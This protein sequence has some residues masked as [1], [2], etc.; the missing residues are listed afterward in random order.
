MSKTDYNIILKYLMDESSKGLSYEVVKLKYIKD[1]DVEAREVPIVNSQFEKACEAFPD[2]EIIQKVLSLQFI[3]DAEC[4]KY[5]LLDPEAKKVEEITVHALR[6]MFTAE[7]F[8]H[9]QRYRLNTT[10]MG[11]NPNSNALFYTDETSFLKK[12]NL[13]RP[14][15]W[16]VEYFF[17]DLKPPVTPLPDVYKEYL[18]HLTNKSELSYTYLLNFMASCVQANKKAFT[19][20]TL[21]GGQGIGKGVLFHILKGLLGPENVAEIRANRL[22]EVK[23]NAFAKN[24]K[25]LFFDELCIRNELDEQQ[26][27]FYVNPTLEIEEKGKDSKQYINYANILIASNSMN[28][29]RVENDDRRYS[30]ADMGPNKLDILSNSKYKM[31]I[32]TYVETVLLNKSNLE[33]LGRFLLNFKIDD[34][35]INDPIKSEAKKNQKL[36]SLQ[37]W[38]VAIF[39]QMAPTYA[40]KELTLPEA[41]IALQ[42]ITDNSKINPGREKWN[43]LSQKVPGFFKRTKK[44]LENGSQVYCIKFEKLDNQPKYI[45]SESED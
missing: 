2:F 30:F 36:H 41:K 5:Y 8:K 6:T 22:A 31:E 38:E 34:N 24:K 29:L 45:A 37:D 15:S 27:K 19:Y 20:C 3:M 25:L 26:L 32:K 10:K 35:M 16:Q 14:A 42:D 7:A 4:G 21:L 40:G 1:K 39:R 23:F 12:V 17:E 18:E 33:Q 44:Y 9:I 28:N 11:Y 13:Y 43:Q